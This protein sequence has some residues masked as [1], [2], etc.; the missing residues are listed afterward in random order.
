MFQTI[1]VLDTA[2]SALQHLFSI[3][4]LR[5]SEERSDKKDKKLREFGV[6]R[7]AHD[8]VLHRLKP[9]TGQAQGLLDT[10]RNTTE[11]TFNYQQYHQVMLVLHVYQS[12]WVSL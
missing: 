2:H 12:Q 5:L 4:Q 7:A 9:G 3:Q 1:S 8:I 11:D 10:Q 6:Y